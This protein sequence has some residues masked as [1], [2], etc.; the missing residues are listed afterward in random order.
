MEVVNLEDIGAGSD[1]TAGSPENW[2]VLPAAAQGEEEE[3]APAAD[4]PARGDVF[5]VKLDAFEGPLE[6]LLHLVR[7]HKLDINDIP[8]AFITEQY[9][10]YIEMMRK[11]NINIASDYLV[12]ASWLL[13]IKSRTLLPQAGEAEEEDPEILR[14]EL[15]RQLLEYQRFKRLSQT[16]RQAEE[17]QSWVYVRGGNGDGIMLDPAG[18]EEPRLQVTVFDLVSA[19]QHL[20]ESIGEEGVHLV[21]IDEMEMADRQ[22]FLLDMLDKAG[23]EGV[24]FQ[25]LFEGARVLAVVVTFLALLELIRK[26]LVVARQSAN[27]AEIRIAKAVK[28]E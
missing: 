5:R 27:F 11:L 2:E 25:K 9:L 13:D 15:Q 4:A 19:I 10:G 12:M 16:F 22:T 3:A 20:I 1:R 6:L 7:E 14:Q 24:V 8:I 17:E 26:N 18:A 28:D 23:A 21:E